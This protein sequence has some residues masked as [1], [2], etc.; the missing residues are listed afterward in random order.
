VAG[1]FVAAFSVMEGREA[2]EGELVANEE[3]D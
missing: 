3:E 2:W 1:F